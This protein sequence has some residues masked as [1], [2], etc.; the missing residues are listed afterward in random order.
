M[1][2]EAALSA[3]LED[4][5]K[6]I[7]HIV[8]EKEAARAKDIALRLDVHSS[9]VTG[10]LRSLV[11]KG[12]INYAPYD[13]VTLT[14]RGKKVAQDVERRHQALSDFFVKVLAVDQDEADESAC[15]ME[16]AVSKNIRDRLMQFVELVEECPPAVGEWL[17]KI[18]FEFE[19][20]DD[21]LNDDSKLPLNELR[22][23]QKGRITHIESDGD[24]TRRIMDMG[25][26]P[27][28]MVEV[29]RI[30]PLGDPIEVKVKGYSLSLRKEEARRIG[31][32]LV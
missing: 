4:Y 6:A 25:M 1:S 26:T 3:S 30:A 13:V 31:V 27:G 7:L 11:S 20:R 29:Q 8:E 19:H 23:G 12:L 28:S 9:S 21:G 5:L 14:P 18:G 32:E 2:A 10:A 16:H 24:V 15:K 22:P 17:E